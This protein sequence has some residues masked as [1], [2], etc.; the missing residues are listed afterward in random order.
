MHL[1]LG[2]HSVDD[3]LLATSAKYEIFIS[4]SHQ[5]HCSGAGDGLVTKGNCDQDNRAAQQLFLAITAESLT[6]TE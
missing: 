6:A 5:G 3:E 2:K 1:P 4:H